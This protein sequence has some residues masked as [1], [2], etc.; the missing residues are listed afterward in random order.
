MDETFRNLLKKQGYAFCGEHSCVKTCLWLKK[1]MVGEGFCYKQKFYGIQS[2]RCVQMT[3]IVSACTQN[4]LYCWRPAE[5]MSKEKIVD[6]PKDIVD[7]C[8][9]AQRKLIVGFKGNPKVKKEVFEEAW[10][11]KHFAISL[12]GEPMLYPYMS[13]FLEEIHKRDMTSFLVT[14]GTLPNALKNLKVMPTQLYISLSAPNEKIYNSL[15]QPIIKQNWEN[16]NK[17]LELL[18]SLDTRKVIRITVVKGYND[19]DLE[20]YAK[21]I[22]KAN[23][24]FVEV[25]SFV[26]VGNAKYRLSPKNQMEHTEIM[27]MADKLASLLG[28][29]VIDEKEESRVALVAKED[30][31]WRILK[32]K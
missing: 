10:N 4:C 1:A 19:T 12:A 24:H 27:E 31:P 13:E 28:W 5:Y 18:P 25:K 3:P 11:P 30:Y 26:S 16:L 8:I 6:K 7:K 9:E 32:V 21:L 29:K 2:H 17:T 23:P 20:G 15:C 22:S 14:N